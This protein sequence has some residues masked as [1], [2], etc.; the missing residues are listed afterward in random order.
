M[1]CSHH[2]SIGCPSEFGT[3]TADG[4]ARVQD[5]AVVSAAQLR[6]FQ[7]QWQHLEH[8]EICD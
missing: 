7:Q 6:R 4:T 2:V 8:D 5:G 1:L 3:A